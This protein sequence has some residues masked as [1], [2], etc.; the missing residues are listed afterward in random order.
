M[1]LSLQT[2][3]TAEQIIDICEAA[4]T[5]ARSACVKGIP[6][7]DLADFRGIV[8]DAAID[9]VVHCPA[10]Q[11]QWIHFPCVRERT[12]N[13]EPLFEDTRLEAGISEADWSRIAD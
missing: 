8:R 6:F 2:L 7:T 11:A 10:P 5:R 3:L 4:S 12:D 13:S 1:S 9:D